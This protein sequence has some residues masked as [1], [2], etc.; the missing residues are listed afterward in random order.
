MPVLFHLSSCF[1]LHTY[2]STIAQLSGC[3]SLD[4]TCHLP[5]PVGMKLACEDSQIWDIKTTR[6][7]GA[8]NAVLPTQSLVLALWLNSMKINFQWVEVVCRCAQA[9]AAHTV[10]LHMCRDA[11]VVEVWSDFFAHTLCSIGG[12]HTVPHMYQWIIKNRKCTHLIEEPSLIE[13]LIKLAA[14]YDPFLI[15][16]FLLTTL[17]W[18]II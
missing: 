6:A 11:I 10:T 13:L 8:S 16:F 2:T 14:S 15:A 12:G 4:L 3:F 5:L 1:L 7:V 17:N 9:D 18:S